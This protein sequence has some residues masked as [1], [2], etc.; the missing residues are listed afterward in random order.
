MLLPSCISSFSAEEVAEEGT[1]PHA[2]E[3]NN[4]PRILASRKLMD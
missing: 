3:A 4:T 1:S 2:I